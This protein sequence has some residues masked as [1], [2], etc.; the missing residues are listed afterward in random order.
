MALAVQRGE[1]V[2]NGLKLE[3]DKAD[4]RQTAQEWLLQLDGV[5]L[6]RL[7]RAYSC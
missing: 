3:C 1:D 5:R 7:R 2:A 4:Q 6:K